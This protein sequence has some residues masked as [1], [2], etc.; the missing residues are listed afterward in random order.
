MV[1]VLSRNS[2]NQTAF[3]GD[4]ARYEMKYL[5][6]VALLPQLRD[7]VHLF[8][9]PDPYCRGTPAQYETTTLQLDNVYGALCL[10]KEN[11]ALN[12]FK[13]RAR[14]Y[15]RAEASPLFLEIKR[16]SGDVIIK[17]RAAIAPGWKSLEDIIHGGSACRKQH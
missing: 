2:P 11:K 9:D 8:C 6:N 17:S 16:K 5:V 4:L 7:F 13:L 15:G 14:I 1:P 10:M 12:R 3:N